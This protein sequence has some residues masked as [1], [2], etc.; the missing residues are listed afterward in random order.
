MHREC[1]YG[2]CI[3]WNLDRRQSSASSIGTTHAQMERWV[4]RSQENHDRAALQRKRQSAC[5]LHNP[6]SNQST[7]EHQRDRGQAARCCRCEVPRPRLKANTQSSKGSATCNTVISG[8]LLEISHQQYAWP[9]ARRES[10]QFVGRAIPVRAAPCP[11]PSPKLL[12][13]CLG[14]GPGHPSERRRAEL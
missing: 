14:G 11:S 12:L 4:Q 8:C 10:A 5:L 6:R 2:L 1:C 7:A 9:G 13:P 3:R